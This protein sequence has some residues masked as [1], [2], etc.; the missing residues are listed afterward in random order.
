[1]TVDA[2]WG[3]GMVIRRG[4]FVAIIGP[5]GAGKSKLPRLIGGLDAPSDGDV[6][7]RG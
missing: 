6:V 1:M 7:L 4:E 5:A 3:V 2:L